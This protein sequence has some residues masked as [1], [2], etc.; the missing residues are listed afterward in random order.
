M[1]PVLKSWKQVRI[2]PLRCLGQISHLKM[3]SY[4][5]YTAGTITYRYTAAAERNRPSPEPAIHLATM[6]VVKFGDAQA[7][8]EH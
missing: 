1:A 7:D 3:V 6:S 2:R 4:D 8:W 5:R